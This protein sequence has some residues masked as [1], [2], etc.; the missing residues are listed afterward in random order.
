ME[1]NSASR[2]TFPEYKLAFPEYKQDDKK[3]GE[4]F[5]T[6]KPIKMVKGGIP[7]PMD[8]NED[9]PRN[10]FY[11]PKDPAYM[12]LFDEI[13]KFDNYMMD[14]INKLKNNLS[15]NS[16]GCLDEDATK[17]CIQ[18]RK[19]IYQRM[20]HSSDPENKETDNIKTDVE[21]ELYGSI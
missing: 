21:Y 16:C 11:I 20:I 9:M 2:L 5:M 19:I 1:K 13:E 18:C 12:E 8:H 10:Y 6:T 14:E 15:T 7:K 4:F 17:K 3:C